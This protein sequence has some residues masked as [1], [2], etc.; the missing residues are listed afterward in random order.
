MLQER[1]YI[2]DTELEHAQRELQHS[3]TCQA[4]MQAELQV[5]KGLAHTSQNSQQLLSHQHDQHDPA[6]QVR[7][8]YLKI[9]SCHMG[10]IA[11]ALMPSYSMCCLLR[12]ATRRILCL[13][14][15]TMWHG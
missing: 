6:S 1:K 13:A 11:A 7:L 10:E 2:V 4:A 3:R 12:A 9:S 8:Q 14:Y 5:L 15:Q